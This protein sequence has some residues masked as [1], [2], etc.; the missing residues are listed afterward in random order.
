VPI[1]ILQLNQGQ[2]DVYPKALEVQLGSK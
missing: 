2:T 1:L